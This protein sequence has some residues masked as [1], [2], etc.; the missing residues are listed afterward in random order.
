M[1]RITD[2]AI[3]FPAGVYE[4]EMMMINELAAG[5]DLLVISPHTDDA[6]IGLGG[7][8]R[9]L[10][11]QGRRVWAVDLTRGELATN[12]TP[13]ERWVEAGRA[14]VVLGLTGR[15]QLTLPDG[16]VDGADRA[17]VADLV[18]V[19]RCLRPR[20]V[21]TAPDP[22]R[23]PDHRATPGLVARACFLSR[24]AA[25]QP[26]LPEARYWADGENFGEPV[27]RWEVEALFAVC[28]DDGEASLLFDVSGTWPAKEQALACYES[29][30][31]RG[32]RRPTAIND[33][34]FLEKIQRRGRN[35]GRR[36]GVRY[37]E[38]LQSESIPVVTDLPTERWV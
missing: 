17:Q 26:E 3:G 20:W 10:A 12:A 29:Q 22:V 15:A 14:S 37:A 28:A 13:E 27:D 5:C 33:E 34:S 7:T 35:W 16:F 25:W 6:E 1:V 32:E 38:A 23:H 19:L 30:F 24:L 21:A 8:I 9:L 31:A 2:R 18:A 4:R 11:D 36:A